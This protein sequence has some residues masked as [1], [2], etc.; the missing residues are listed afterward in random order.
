M[1]LT[2][3]ALS[4]VA[5]DIT[6]AIADTHLAA[7]HDLEFRSL[8]ATTSIEQDCFVQR[9]YYTGVQTGV[10]L[11]TSTAVVTGTSGNGTATT[12]SRPLTA[13]AA[14]VN[15]SASVLALALGLVVVSL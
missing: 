13:G 6:G 10:A 11:P 15:L 2:T 4:L 7:H 5:I 14:S 1:K 9:G 12:T 3:A 8:G